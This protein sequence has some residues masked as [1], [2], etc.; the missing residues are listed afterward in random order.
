MTLNPVLL[1][2]LIARSAVETFPRWLAGAGA[3]VVPEPVEIEADTPASRE[4]R[5][6]RQIESARAAGMI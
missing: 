4:A 3:V 5:M 1:G 6:L 2:T